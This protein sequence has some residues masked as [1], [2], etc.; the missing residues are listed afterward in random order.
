MLWSFLL[1]NL[2]TLIVAV[3]MTAMT[4]LK[5]RGVS[6]FDANAGALC[7]GALAMTLL[8]LF[9]REFS[10]VPMTIDFW[11]ALLYSALFATVVAFLAFFAL[12]RSIGAALDEF[13]GGTAPERDRTL[14][15]VRRCADPVG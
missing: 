11:L 8:A 2:G 13:T 10:Q 1:A 9:G 4:H 14:L 7:Y 3:G 15:V 12:A 6:L 5:E